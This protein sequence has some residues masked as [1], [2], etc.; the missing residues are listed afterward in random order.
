MNKAR[1]NDVV[2]FLIDQTSKVAKQAAQREF[3]L[4]HIGITVDQWVLLKMIQEYQEL[5]QAELAERSHRDPASITR[6]LDLLQKK[7]LVVREAVAGN[8]RQYHIRLTKEGNYFIL[9]HLPLV[10]E[11]RAKALKGFTQKETAQ[12]KDMLQRIQQNYS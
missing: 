6:T 4:L 10:E 3:D 5:S 1:L 11:L 9:Q 2:L 8:R 7:K 12:L